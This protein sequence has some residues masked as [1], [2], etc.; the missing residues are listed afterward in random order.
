MSGGAIAEVAWVSSYKSH[1]SQPW[2]LF[3]L[4]MFSIISSLMP[5]CKY[6]FVPM[7]EADFRIYLVNTFA[8][9]K[10]AFLRMLKKTLRYRDG[11]NHRIL[12]RDGRKVAQFWL[13][14][15]RRIPANMS[16]SSWDSDY[17]LNSLKEC[18]KYSSQETLIFTVPVMLSV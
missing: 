14:V 7:K 10:N 5:V 15:Y 8:A 18:K 16:G 12:C 11:W 1:C 6:P 17:L 2:V 3:F 4:L 13:L 9:P